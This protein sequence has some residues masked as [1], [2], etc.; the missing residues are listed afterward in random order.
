MRGRYEQEDTANSREKRVSMKESLWEQGEDLNPRHRPYIKRTF[1]PMKNK[2]AY[3][4]ISVQDWCKDIQT[5]F[6]DF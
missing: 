5:S 4:P 2:K 6:D 1:L 3:M